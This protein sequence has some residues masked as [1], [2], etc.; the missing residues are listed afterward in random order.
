MLPNRMILID[1]GNYDGPMG[2]KQHVFP[3]EKYVR[4]PESF[5]TEAE[6]REDGELEK[7]MWGEMEVCTEGQVEQRN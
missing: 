4:E 3:A 7:E 5:L 1:N 2:K 6:R